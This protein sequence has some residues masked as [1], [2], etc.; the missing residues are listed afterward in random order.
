MADHRGPKYRTPILVR[1]LLWVMESGTRFVCRMR[2][3]KLD[4]W[5]TVAFCRRPF[6]RYRPGGPRG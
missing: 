3:H 5:S 6:C 4:S 1:P 2:G